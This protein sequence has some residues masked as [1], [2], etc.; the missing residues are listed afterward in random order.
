MRLSESIVIFGNILGQLRYALAMYDEY[1]DKRLPEY[2]YYD[3]KFPHPFSMLAEEKILIEL[4]NF[5]NESKF[6]GKLMKW[7]VPSEYTALK[8]RL[9]TE[10]WTKKIRNQLIA[11]KRR[12]KSGR[13]ISIQEMSAVFHPDPEATRQ[14]GGELEIV[15]RAILWFYMKEPWFPKLKEIVEQQDPARFV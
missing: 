10:S 9:K 15:L 14:L 12:D 6:Y 11:H 7:Q 8:R 3:G 4:S 2:E 5:D 1:F 13:F